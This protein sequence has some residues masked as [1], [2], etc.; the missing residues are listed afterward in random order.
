MGD[1]SAHHWAIFYF[2][3]SVAQIIEPLFSAVKSMDIKGYGLILTNKHW[4]GQHGCQI[5]SLCNIPKREKYNQTTTKNTK[6]QYN[7]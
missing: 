5:F 1:F 7:I 3:Q 4:T 6:G 2:K